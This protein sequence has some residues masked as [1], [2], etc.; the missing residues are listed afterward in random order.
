MI[1]LPEAISG[2][3]THTFFQVIEIMCRKGLQ[4]RFKKNGKWREPS[5]SELVQILC[6]GESGIKLV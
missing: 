5:V 1:A 6:T 3:P 4:F 2:V